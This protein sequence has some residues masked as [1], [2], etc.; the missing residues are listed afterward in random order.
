MTTHLHSDG[1]PLTET[2]ITY[3]KANFGHE[4]GKL[5]RYVE[6]EFAEELERDKRKAEAQLAVAKRW[7]ENIACSFLYNYPPEYTADA[8]DAQKA[9]AEIKAIETVGRTSETSGEAK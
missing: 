1:L 9:L 7:L 2:P 6:R 5:W 8:E 3:V 4:E